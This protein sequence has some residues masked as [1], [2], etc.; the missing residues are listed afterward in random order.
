MVARDGRVIAE[1][2]SQ[3]PHDEGFGAGEATAKVLVEQV[4]RALRPAVAR[5][6]A[7]ADRCRAA[8]A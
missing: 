8:R 2:K 4:E 3:T 6:V 1:M 5:P 7:G